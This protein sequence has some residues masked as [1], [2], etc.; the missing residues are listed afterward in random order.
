ML[1]DR[2]GDAAIDRLLNLSESLAATYAATP[3]H[4]ALARDA[5]VAELLDLAAEVGESVHATLKLV[6]DGGR[7]HV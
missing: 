1:H 2:V 4:A 3:R 6:A 7:W 5:P